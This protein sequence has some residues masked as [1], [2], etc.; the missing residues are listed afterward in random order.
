M[1]MAKDTFI[2]FLLTDD[3]PFADGVAWVRSKISQ[4]R[5]LWEITTV[6]GLIE[7]TLFHRIA[8]Q[9]ARHNAIATCNELL[10]LSLVRRCEIIAYSN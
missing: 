10:T 2:E 5:E 3:Q 9:S 1:A 4:A 6:E 8:A 7:S